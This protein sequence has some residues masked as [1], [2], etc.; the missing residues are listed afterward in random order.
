MA[1]A[2]ARLV[3]D[4]VVYSQKPIGHLKKMVGLGAPSRGRRI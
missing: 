2:K 3:R 4:G 1:M